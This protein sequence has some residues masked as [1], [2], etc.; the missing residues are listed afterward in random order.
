[1]NYKQEDYRYY[2]AYFKNDVLSRIRFFKDYETCLEEADKLFRDKVYSYSPIS[3][4]VVMFD[5]DC[6][7]EPR[8]DYACDYEHCEEVSVDAVPMKVWN[9]VERPSFFVLTKDENATDTKLHA[10][11]TK[12]QA[13]AYANAYLRVQLEDDLLVDK[14]LIQF[15]TSRQLHGWVPEVSGMSHDVYVLENKEE[16]YVN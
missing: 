13:I 15:V 4:E 1:M 2:Y 6:A 9:R 8:L 11:S 7:G 14:D 10:F 5:K 3:S 16:Y 12:R